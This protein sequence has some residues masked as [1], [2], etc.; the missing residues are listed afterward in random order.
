MRS[1]SSSTRSHLE[2]RVAQ[3][4]KLFQV[5]GTKSLDPVR[6]GCS[7][8]GGGLCNPVLIPQT[9]ADNDLPVHLK[10]GAMD[11][12]LYRLTM[13]LTLGG[14]CRARWLAPL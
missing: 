8:A 9:Q 4:Q 12:I 3:K 14:E 2:N 11:N 6:G 5:G 1:F 7:W 13:T 10:G